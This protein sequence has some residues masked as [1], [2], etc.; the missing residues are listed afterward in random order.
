MSLKFSVLETKTFTLLYSTLSRAKF[1]RSEGESGQA[2]AGERSSSMRVDAHQHFWFYN[3]EE[4]A[5]IDDS[6]APLR[7]DFLPEDLCPELEDAGFDGTVAVQVRQSVAETKWL[8]ELAARVPYIA[9][10]VGW[11][12]LQAPDIDRQLEPLAADPK[13]VGI[14]HIVQSEPDDCFLLRP[15]FLCGIGALEKFDLAYDILIYPRHLPAAKEFVQRF[16]RQ[17]FVLDHLAKP[18]IKS[19]ALEPWSRDLR[20]LAEF[21]NVYCK[22]SGL[23]TEADWRN[24]K[25]ADIAPYLDVAMECFGPERLM[26][27]SDWPVCTLAAPYR[28]VMNLVSEYLSGESQAVQDAIFGG[29]AVT[30]WNLQRRSST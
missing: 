5:W 12:D 13:L 30:F 9:G 26:V 29:N 20:R 7:R 25:P 2:M 15:Q 8:L 3:P 16:P 4:Y 24:W 28:N 6:M 21:Q 19:A 23:V 27:G 22:L 17:R 1:P 10:V 18:S 11:I 14:R